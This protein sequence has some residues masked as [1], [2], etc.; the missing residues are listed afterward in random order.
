MPVTAWQNVSLDFALDMDMDKMQSTACIL[1]AIDEALQ[2]H[3]LLP[4]FLAARQSSKGSYAHVLPSS[5]L[6]YC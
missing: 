3:S 2:Q 4:P 6:H 5:S 1:T